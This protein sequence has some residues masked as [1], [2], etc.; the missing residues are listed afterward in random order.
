[1]IRASFLHVWAA[2]LVFSARY[3]EGL[4]IIS[5]QID[6]VEKYRLSFA[7]PHSYLRKADACRGLRRFGSAHG[8]LDKALSFASANDEY[9]PS[10]VAISR[11]ITYM[12]QQ[13]FSD[14]LSS[15][16]GVSPRV[17]PGGLGEFYACR[18]FA[19]ACTGEL[20]E[21]RK[22]FEKADSVTSLVESRVFAQLGRSVA[23]LEEGAQN[24]RTVVAQA[25]A[26]VEET[27]YFDI[28]VSAYR[29][30]PPLLSAVAHDSES[31]IL[32]SQLVT[33]ARDTRLGRDAG[34]P[35]GP[36]ERRTEPLTARERDVY[37]LL[38]EGLTNRE[39]AERLF[40]SEVT[41]KVHVRHILS[42][43]NVRS[44]TEAVLKAPTLLDGQATS[45]TE[46]SSND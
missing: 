15:L 36:A 5:D 17:R 29:A 21:A 37:E 13:R 25:F 23:A 38:T 1:M 19:F 10:A 7:L 2:A 4:K 46:R 24:A 35:L 33:R 3:S 27:A 34:L 26:A 28:F 42:K 20:T 6:E 41:V 12:V 22:W 31:A 8:Y 40:V 18:G 39:I 30:Y 45:A 9:V 32:L 44:R 11:A 16:G 43:L 14:A